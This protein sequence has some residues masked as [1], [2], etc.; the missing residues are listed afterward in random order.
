MKHT[1]TD[2]IQM[3]SLPLESKVLM[4]ER[5]IAEWIE[6]FG[7]DGVYVSF[8]GGKD[9]TVLLHM[10]RRL[11]PNVPAVFVDTGLE[12]P[13]IREFVKTFDNVVWLRPKMNFKQVIE[14][15]GYP[16]ISKEV[17]DCVDGARKYLNCL[18]KKKGSEYRL[19]RLNGALKDKNGNY[20]LFNQ[21]KYKF[22]LEA[23][24][25]ISAKCCDVMKKAPALSFEK[26]E[27]RTPILGVMASESYIRTQRW[28]RNGCNAFD[29]KRPSSKPMS[30]WTEQDV[31][32]YIKEN[33]LPICSVYGD[34]VVDY[35]RMEQYENQMSLYDYE[36]SEAGRPLLK[37]TGANRT[38]CMFCG[39]GCHLEKSP[40]RF[41]RMKETHPKQYEYI[42]KPTTDGGLGY[43]NVIDWINQ[44]GEMNI[45]Y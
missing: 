23:E 17:S 4:T 20:S 22:F 16:F 30:F 43:K 25:N 1:R 6:R 38:G 24:F 21:E 2:L 39:F 19:R 42:M 40:N 36:I 31:L 35:E 10:V 34:I 32:L 5:R 27:G 26:K 28:L 15:Y 18:D 12:Y 8:S 37:T 29:E 3:Q 13:E 14:K 9:S 11:Y 7:E 45:K 44:N 41:E 33:N